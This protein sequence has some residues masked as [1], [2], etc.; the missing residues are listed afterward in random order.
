MKIPTDKFGSADKITARVA[1]ETS[2]V[3]FEAV[4]S[5]KGI[6]QLDLLDDTHTLVLAR[7]DAGALNLEA[8]ALP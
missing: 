8:L 5:M 4:T 6:E 3:P 1:T 2:G 7:S